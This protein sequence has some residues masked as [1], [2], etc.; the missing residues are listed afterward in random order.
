M[1][2]IMLVKAKP[3]A[4]NCWR[5]L[6]NPGNEYCYAADP[7]LLDEMQKALTLERFQNEVDAGLRSM[8]HDDDDMDD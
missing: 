5:S 2:R 8:D 7:I 3:G 4:D 1:I 6:M